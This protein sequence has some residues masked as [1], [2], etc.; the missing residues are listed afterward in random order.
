[1][2]TKIILAV[3]LIFSMLTGCTEFE[4]SENIGQMTENETANSVSDGDVIVSFINVGQAESILIQSYDGKNMLIDAGETIDDAVINYLD[5]AGVNKLDVVIATHPHSDHISDMANVIKKYEIGTFY[6]PDVTHT[7]KTFE[8]MESAHEDKNVNVEEAKNGID[9][10]F[11]EDVKCR[12]VAPC[13]KFYDDLNNYSAVLRMEYGNTSF[14]FT[15]D[16]EEQS[17]REILASGENIR[18]DVL[19]VGHHGSSSSTSESFLDKVKPSIAVISCGTD[20]E[21]GHPHKETIE[22]LDE[23]GITTYITRDE[24]KA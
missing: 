24:D 19:D 22:K 11:S 1:M 4:T 15:G 2:N 23:R 5:G 3:C 6:M 9:V 7:S 14:L 20:N 8:K 12:M 13:S 10:P 18:A 21:Y 17:E 16:A